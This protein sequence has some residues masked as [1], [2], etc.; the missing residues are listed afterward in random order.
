MRDAINK[1]AIIV[2]NHCIKHRIGTI[3]F[4]RN[5]DQRQEAE[6]GKANQP[7]V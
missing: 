1:A 2:I 5:K 4:V 6:L 3:V 7:F